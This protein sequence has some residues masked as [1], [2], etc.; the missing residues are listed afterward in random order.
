[1]SALVGRTFVVSAILTPAIAISATLLPRNRAAMA[2]ILGGVI[3]HLILN[4]IAAL[5]VGGHVR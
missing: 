3:P 5:V 4:G 2:V 1:M